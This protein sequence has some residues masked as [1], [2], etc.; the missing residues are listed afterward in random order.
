MQ[1][2]RVRKN[3]EF[4]RAARYALAHR[5]VVRHAPQRVRFAERPCVEQNIRRPLERA[6]RERG[7]AAQVVEPVAVERHHKAM[8]HHDV[9]N[10]HDVPVVRVSAVE[11][12]DALDFVKEQHGGRF[13]A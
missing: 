9:G 10:H 5:D 1:I 6:A 4:A 3:L 2:A 7:H 13:D 8:P 12:Q 11:R